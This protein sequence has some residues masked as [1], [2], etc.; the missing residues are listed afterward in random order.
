MSEPQPRQP[1]LSASFI[2]V[3]YLILAGIALLLAK[4]LG[5][6]NLLVWHR[7]GPTP[8]WVDA[9]MG[10]GVGVVVVFLSDLMDQRFAWSRRLGREFGRTLG[11][12]TLSD[13]FIFALASGVAEELL[14]RGFL[15][16]FL[17][18][19]AFSGPWAEWLGLGA[20]SLIF[21]VLH[22]GRNLKKMLPW[23]AMAVL[24]GA[25]FGWMYL[26]TGNVLAPIIAHFTINFFNLQSISRDY[27][28]LRDDEHK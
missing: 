1:R 11:R 14:F 6:L 2:A 24:L 12:L 19:V 20:A 21:G 25:V 23:T 5:D 18:E 10:A 16:Q 17:S 7:G 22:I 26:Y 28:H 27:G 8:V 15:Q 3:F 4:W 9:L 13:A